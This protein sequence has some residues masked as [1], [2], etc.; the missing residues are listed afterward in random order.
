[1]EKEIHLKLLRRNGNIMQVLILVI[2]IVPLFIYMIFGLEITVGIVF[3]GALFSAIIIM[4][5]DIAV[6]HQME[7]KISQ[8]E[9]MIN[10]GS[11]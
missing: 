10:N 4:N 8:M 6:V 11:I 7:Q 2:F 9:S 1:M 5:Y 3:T